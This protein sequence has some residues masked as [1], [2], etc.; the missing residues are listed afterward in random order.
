MERCLEMVFRR[1]AG[2]LR[3]FGGKLTFRFNDVTFVL[4]NH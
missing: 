2:L 1:N 4:F 3:I